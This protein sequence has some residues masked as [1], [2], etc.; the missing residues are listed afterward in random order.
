MSERDPQSPAEPR[1]DTPPVDVPHHPLPPPHPSR[2]EH[3]TGGEGTM[4]RML[5][6]ALGRAARHIKV[7]PQTGLVVPFPTD[8]A[9]GDADAQAPAVRPAVSDADSAA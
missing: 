2:H 9:D 3:E 7:D 5:N 8:D 4:E 1:E 6:E